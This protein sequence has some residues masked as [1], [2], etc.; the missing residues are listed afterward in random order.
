MTKEIFI[1]GQLI[2]LEHRAC[3]SGRCEKLFWVMKTSTQSICCG[4]CPEIIFGR[5]RPKDYMPP[6]RL[7]GKKS[8]SVDMPKAKGNF[9][10]K[11]LEMSWKKAQ[12]KNKENYLKLV[13]DRAAAQAKTS[14]QKHGQS[15]LSKPAPLRL[16]R[17]S[18]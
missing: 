1:D 7:A 8:L 14:M 9:K 4:E 12:N 6:V 5:P 2:D 11:L 13:E 18:L 15:A 16:V 17:P 3:A 10:N